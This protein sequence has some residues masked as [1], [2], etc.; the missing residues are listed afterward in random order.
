MS[1]DDADLSLFQEMTVKAL[2]AEVAPSYEGWEE[3]GLVDRQ[4]WN[5]LGDA[6][7]LGANTSEMFGGAG[8]PASVTFMIIYE[9]S[10]LNFGGF[11]SSFNI[12][13]N[14]VMPY[15]DRLGTDNQKNKWLPKMVTGEAVGALAMTEPGAGSDVAGIRTTAKKDGDGWVLNGSK[16]FI[17]NGI[18]ADLIIVAAKTDPEKGAKGISL[19]LLDTR[20]E[21]FSRGS[22]IEKI[23]QMASDT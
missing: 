5:K 17:T 18:H 4:L 6:G 10:R 12:H 21:G 15:I 11:S 1:F 9:M 23:G 3:A 7:L 16:I 22:K 13:S 8:A 20:A 14:I 2:E 19:F